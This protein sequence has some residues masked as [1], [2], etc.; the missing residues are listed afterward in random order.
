M[1]SYLYGEFL[2]DPCIIKRG[3]T[4]LLSCS[5]ETSRLYTQG[6]WFVIL[7]GDGDFDESLFCDSCT[8]CGFRDDGPIRCDNG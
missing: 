1:V 4:E 7:Q 2:I 5:D 6:R 3:I 8:S